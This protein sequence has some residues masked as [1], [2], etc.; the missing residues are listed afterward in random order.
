MTATANRV[1]KV[2]SWGLVGIVTFEVVIRGLS[3]FTMYV[4][5]DPRI[6]AAEW[7]TQHRLS[8]DHILLPDKDPNSALFLIRAP[9]Q[10]H[11]FNFYALS[12]DLPEA[13]AEYPSDISQ[14]SQLLTQVQYIVVPSQRVYSSAFRLPHRFPN[15]ARFFEAL[16]SGELHF[17]PEFQAST[18]TCLLPSI[19]YPIIRTWLCPLPQATTE[20]T[21]TVYDHP[22]VSIWKKHLPLTA[23]NYEKILLDRY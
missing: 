22:T 16:F 23:D 14:L 9:E 5:T 13:D 3:F 7:L 12:G 18:T 1:Q 17:T 6:Q 10:V 2:I 8:S 20:E 4:Q 21:F 19:T 11:F 15:E